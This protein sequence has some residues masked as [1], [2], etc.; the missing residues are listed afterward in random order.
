MRGNPTFA[1]GRRK[2]S[3]WLFQRA[4]PVSLGACSYH[5]VPEPSLGTLFPVIAPRQGASQRRKTRILPNIRLAGGVQAQLCHKWD[6]VELTTFTMRKDAR[7]SL[8]L[9]ARGRW[10]NVNSVLK[11]DLHN[12]LLGGAYKRV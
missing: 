4:A 3:T 9:D 10:P 1:S 6:K 11:P 5:C 2:W 7:N 8:R 12:G